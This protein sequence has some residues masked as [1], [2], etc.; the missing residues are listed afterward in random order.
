M[1]EDWADY[2][3]R[4]YEKALDRVIADAQSKAPVPGDAPGDAHD[5]AG[6]F[7]CGELWNG[8]EARTLAE[9]HRVVTGHEYWLI[10]NPEHEEDDQT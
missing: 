6:C 8:P 3:T 7:Q 5:K 4:R 10:V 2:V 9:A 1:S